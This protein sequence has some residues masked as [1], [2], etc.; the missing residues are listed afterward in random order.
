MIILPSGRVLRPNQNIIGIDDEMNLSEGYDGPL[1]DNERWEDDTNW[2][3]K[4]RIFLADV[5]IKRWTFY[6]EN[7]TNKERWDD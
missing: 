4:D 7:F 6:K 2:P 1:L 5:M 3:N